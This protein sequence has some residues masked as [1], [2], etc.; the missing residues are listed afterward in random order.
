MTVSNTTA[1]VAALTLAGALSA[2]ASSL[3]VSLDAPIF[4]DTPVG[5]QFRNGQGPSDP[6]LFLA[7]INVGDTNNRATA[8]YT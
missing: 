8:F 1:L 2:Q 4:T 5:V 6:Q 7:P 3:S